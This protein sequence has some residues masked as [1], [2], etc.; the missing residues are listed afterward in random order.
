MHDAS[1]VDEHVYATVFVHDHPHHIAYGVGVGHV[2]VDECS[3]QL[4]CGMGTGFIVYLG[5]DHLRTR[6]A[7]GA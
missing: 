1:V 4:L 5:D 6:V 3:V 2:G 7:Q